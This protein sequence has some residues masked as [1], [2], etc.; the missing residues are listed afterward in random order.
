MFNSIEG[1][2]LDNPKNEEGQKLRE[3]FEQL[4]PAQQFNDV[5]RSCNQAKILDGAIHDVKGRF[6]RATREASI[7]SSMTITSNGIEIRIEDKLGRITFALNG[8]ELP[9]EEKGILFEINV[10][11][12]KVGVDIETMI[13]ESESATV[14]ATRNSTSAKVTLLRAI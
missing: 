2:D 5:I 9:I 14:E 11:L 3:Y 13:R 12:Q 8:E 4:N 7:G 6:I 10:L 1:K